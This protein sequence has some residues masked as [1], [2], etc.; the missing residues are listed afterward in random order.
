MLVVK[1]KPHTDKF[2]FFE[3]LE[4]K[5]VLQRKW[6][7]NEIIIG[8][9][10]YQIK[11]KYVTK[12]KIGFKRNL[13]IVIKRENMEIVKIDTPSSF[14]GI[15]EYAFTYDSVN[16]CITTRTPREI[17]ILRENVYIGEIRS[18]GLFSNCWEINLQQD[19]PLLIQAFLFY[20]RL[21]LYWGEHISVWKSGKVVQMPANR[22][23]VN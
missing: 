1:Y 20:L 16:Y 12:D 9:D 6:L 13:L 3:L 17:S 10:R 8:N 22:V 2:L 5:A 21:W 18:R 4:E 15:W 23:K 14:G 7:S 19:T 11:Y